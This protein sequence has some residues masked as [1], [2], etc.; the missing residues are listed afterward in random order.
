L[1]FLIA[2]SNCFIATKA[3]DVCLAAS[4]GVLYFARYFCNTTPEDIRSNAKIQARDLR[5]ILS[6]ALSSVAT[7]LGI[8]TTFQ[9]TVEQHGNIENSIL[10][11]VQQSSSGLFVQY[12]KLNRDGQILWPNSSSTT[13]NYTDFIF[14]TLA[15]QVLDDFSNESKDSDNNNILQSTFF[16]SNAIREP[17]TDK[18][19][20]LM[21][22]PQIENSNYTDDSVS[23]IFTREVIAALIGFDHDNNNITFSA[24]IAFIFLITTVSPIATPALFRPRPST[25]IIPLPSSK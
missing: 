2:S 21:L 12:L 16:L 8:L 19:Y 6:N 9:E 17:A 13:S 7:N 3:S 11:I 22:Y 18:T 5:S 4:S 14:S 25:R 23:G 24:G 15:E 10:D 20:S 1:I